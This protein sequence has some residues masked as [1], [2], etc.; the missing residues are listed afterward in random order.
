MRTI[1]Y[2]LI[3]ILTISGCGYS[4]RESMIRNQRPEYLRT[5]NNGPVVSLTQKDIEEAVEFGKNNKH[6]Q[7]VI[8]YAFMFQKDSSR[9]LEVNP[10]SL[11]ILICTNYY[12]I[13]DYA[14]RKTRNYE[15]ID[16]D[17]VNFLAHLPTFQIEVVEK[18]GD[19]IY[20]FLVGSKFVLIKNGIKIEESKENSLYKDHNPY[21]ISH[22][23]GQTSWQEAINES[24]RK[25]M[26]M[27]NK[28]AEQY[29]KDMKIDLKNIVQ[30]PSSTQEHLYDYKDVDLSSKYEIIVI[31]SD[32]EIH[33]PVDFSNIK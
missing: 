7:D 17:Y 23:T 14:A 20:P 11:Y 15:N 27:A 1:V 5:Y 4:I 18:M 8:N 22:L 33:V 9:L 30:I 25:S 19:V 13:A 16:M 29:R 12:L 21:A 6:N 26:E 2:A 3:F 32:R 28:L 31:Y 24:T 10:R